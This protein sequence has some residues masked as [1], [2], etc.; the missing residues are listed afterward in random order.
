MILC[1]GNGSFTWSRG[2]RLRAI[3]SAGVIGTLPSC[4]LSRPAAQT[5]SN[6]P[7]IHEL[8]N[9]VWEAYHSQR[10]IMASA[11]SR[12][13]AQGQAALVANSVCLARGDYGSVL[14]VCSPHLDFA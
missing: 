7:R 13:Y 2:P 10:R 6:D 11:S 1:G 5:A 3:R 4:A 8:L 9:I 14:F 12:R